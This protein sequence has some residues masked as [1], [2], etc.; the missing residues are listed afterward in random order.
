MGGRVTVTMDMPMNLSSILFESEMTILEELGE[1]SVQMA[2]EMWTGWKYGKYYPPEQKG[3]SFAGWKF[4]LLQAK[5]HKRGVEILNDAKSLATGDTYAGYVH[6]A[7][8]PKNDLVWLKVMDRMRRELVPESMDRLMAE[9]KANA[10]RDRTV[11]ELEPN[12]ADAL[13]EV[14]KIQ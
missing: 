2:Q 11:I 6:R 14:F 7:G 8:T 9:L 10:N 5:Q 12:R 3:T 1:E 4:K 13:V